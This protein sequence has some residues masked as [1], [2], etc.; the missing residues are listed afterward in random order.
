VKSSRFTLTAKPTAR[1]ALTAAFERKQQP[2]LGETRISSF[3][4]TTQFGPRAKPTALS[5][6]LTTTSPGQGPTTAARKLALTTAVGRGRSQVKLALSQDSTLQIERDQ[7]ARTVTKIKAEMPGH[8]RMKL[9]TD[10]LQIEDAI[11]QPEQRA[12]RL[13]N[14]LSLKL[15]P[16]D[17]LLLQNLSLRDTQQQATGLAEV[18]WRRAGT[19]SSVE[20]GQQWSQQ[21]G[22]EGPATFV[23]LHLGRRSLPG[24]ARQLGAPGLFADEAK[25]GF[26]P[27]PG[28]VSATSRKGLF[29]DPSRFGFHALSEEDYSGRCGLDLLLKLRQS[30]DGDS[31]SSWGIGY[32]RAL[33]RRTLLRLASQI[34]PEF[35]NG[36]QQGQPQ[37]VRRTLAEIGLPVS[38]KFALLGRYVT[39]Q[40]LQGGGVDSVFLA[41]SGR[42]SSREKLEFLVGTQQGRLDQRLISGGDLGLLYARQVSE[43]HLFFLK[44]NV[45]YGSTVASASGA[46]WQLEVKFQKDI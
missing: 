11:V 46:S 20:A 34:R 4:L 36:D 23:G 35:T 15:S 30:A 33:G 12:T 16:R 44:G 7:L 13:L 38:S 17:E 24:W 31:E 21:A 14:S 3:A 45:T 28:W 25:F 10:Y 41:L 32:R 8:P 6:S 18:S 43:G 19:T 29:A 2:I 1:S 39:D 37:P 42:P 5:A 9:V 40:S 27:L 22:Q 26:H